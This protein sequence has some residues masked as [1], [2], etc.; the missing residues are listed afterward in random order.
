MCDNFA[1]CSGTGKSSSTYCPLRP[2]VSKKV[3]SITFD[4][5]TQKFT[6]IYEI[7]VEN[8]SLTVEPI[9]LLQIWDCAIYSIDSVTV[10]A[11]NSG[12]PVGDPLPVVTVVVNNSTLPLLAIDQLVLGAYTRLTLT[13]VVDKSVAI[14]NNM[15]LVRSGDQQPLFP[16]F[17]V[18]EGVDLQQILC[19]LC[20]PSAAKQP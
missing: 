20:D 10:S 6:I 18:T 11:H 4:T 1:S 8:Q 2:F 9:R 13:L 15:L 19:N 3:S 12:A 14:F 7:H 16:P 5:E 17:Y